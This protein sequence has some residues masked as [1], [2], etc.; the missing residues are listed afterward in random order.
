[1]QAALLIGQLDMLPELA[2]KRAHASALL[3]DALAHI[4][5]IRPLPPQ[6]EMTRESTYCY[7][8]RYSPEERQVSRDLFVAA[9]DA[10]GIPC[11][12]RFY[13]PVYR[14]DL[15]YATPEICPQLSMGREQPVD[16][17]KVVCPVSERAAY[18]EAVWLPQF[19][20]I[21]DHQDIED[22]ASAVAKVMRNLETLQTADPALAGLKALSRAERPKHERGR[23]Y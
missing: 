17:S 11:D 18:D 7:V 1:L 16:Y 2:A 8:F 5:G 12:G 22:I 3:G 10:E 20:L 13:E 23:N 4:A 6:P 19:L 9:L 15:F 21:G 14:S